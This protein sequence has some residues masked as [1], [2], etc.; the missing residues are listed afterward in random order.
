[1]ATLI[2]IDKENGEVS[3]AKNQLKW[4]SASSKV[5]SERTQVHT[6]LQKKMISTSPATSLSVRKALG[7]VNRTLEAPSKKEHLK[8]KNQPCAAK[9]ITEKTAGLESRDAVAE[10][11]YPEM[12]NMFPYDPLDFESFDVPEEHKLSHLTLSGVPLMIFESTSDRLVNMVPSPVK[13]TQMSWECDLLQ[14]TTDFLSTLDEIIDMPPL[15][16]DL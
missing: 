6:P 9:K 14:S 10:E 16:H 4:P 1:M 11:A 3:A 5:I 13:L 7:N 8:Q 2:F 12:E 15:N